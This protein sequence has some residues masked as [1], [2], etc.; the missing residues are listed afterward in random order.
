MLPG[1][2]VSRIIP[3]ETLAGLITGQYKLYGGVIRQAAET[4]HT[5]QI[6]K[7]LIPAALDPLGAIPE[8]NFISVKKL[9]LL[10]IARLY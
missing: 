2:A 3:H 1:W 8:L 7:H 4:P 6:V 10:Y 9:N 5:G